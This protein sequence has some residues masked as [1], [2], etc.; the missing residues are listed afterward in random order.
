ATAPGTVLAALPDAAPEHPEPLDRVLADVQRLIVP[1][2][3]HWNHPGFLAW[4]AITG[5]APGVAAE[6]LTAAF[7]VNA[8]L[9][10]SSPAATELEER[11]CDWVRRLIDLPGDFRG[12]VNDT[13]STSTLVALAAARHQLRGLPGADVRRRGLAGR[14]DLPPLVVYAS[15]QAHSSVDK[16]A[17][18]LGVG[19]ENVRRVASDGAFRMDV[20]ALAEAVAADRAAGRLPMAAVA[21]AGTTSTTSV[22]PLPEIAALCRRERLWLHV[23]AAYAGSAAIC[24]EIRRGALAGLDLGDSLVVNPHKWLATPIDCSL[25][26]VRRPE[27]LRAAFS[28]VPDY[29]VTEEAE[30]T[31]LMDTGFQ[32]GRRFRALKLWMVLRAFGAEGLRER[33]REHCR[34]ARRLA[35]RLAA[36]PRFEVVA[37]VPFSTVCFRTRAGEEAD[38]RLLAEV[39]ADGRFFLSHT[40]LGGRFTLRVAIGNLRTEERHVEAL[41]ELLAARAAGPAAS[42]GDGAPPV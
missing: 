21:T 4:F 34:L 42:A 24:P 33:L 31:N 41:W 26:F 29:L 16:A 39:N 30:V 6:T 37:P 35:E 2:L 36:E 40:V 7:N 32:L 23:D 22:D 17:I 20:A 9:W 12:H 28:L 13:A 19:Q 18:V 3:T 38:R 8:M 5:S 27:V 11:V 15:D 25:L 1:N 10:R 14:P